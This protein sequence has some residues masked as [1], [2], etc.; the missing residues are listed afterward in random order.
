M[1]STENDANAANFKEITGHIGLVQQ[2]L[3]T[4]TAGT[5]KYDQSVE[6]LSDYYE[7]A[8]QD[9]AMRIT[10]LEEVCRGLEATNST[11][12]RRVWSLVLA[13]VALLVFFVFFIFPYHFNAAV[14]ALMPFLTPDRL[15]VNFV[16]VFVTGLLI[17]YNQK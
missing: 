7:R 15:A 1:A 17:K 4:M 10:T 3:K 9:R 12:R 5:E 8:I 11:N 2:R 14:N 13:V 6:D 16:L